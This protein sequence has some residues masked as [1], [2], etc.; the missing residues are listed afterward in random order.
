MLFDVSAYL[1]LPQQRDY[2][3]APDGRRFVMIRNDAPT[4]SRIFVVF[5]FT[6]ELKAR[7]KK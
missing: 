3:I 2:D 4:A 6:K 1:Q 5:G 7:E